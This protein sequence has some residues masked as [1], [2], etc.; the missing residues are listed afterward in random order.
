[1]IKDQ[2]ARA[3]QSV[4][5]ISASNSKRE[6]ETGVPL[7]TTYHPRLKDLSGLIKRSLQYVMQTKKLTQFLHLHHLFL[8]GVPEI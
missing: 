4:S 3:L 6:K 1:M 5:N 2:V 7:G 8:S